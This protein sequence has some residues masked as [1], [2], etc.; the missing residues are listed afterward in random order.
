M[1]PSTAN[2]W[3]IPTGTQ[4]K[5]RLFLLRDE[6]FAED[7]VVI[8]AKTEQQVQWLKEHTSIKIQTETSSFWDSAIAFF[9]G[10]DSIHD[11]LLRLGLDPHEA[12][13][14]EA[15]ID[16]GQYFVYADKVQ[17]ANLGQVDDSVRHIK[18]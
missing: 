14:A 11:V 18:P 12:V 2:Y 7:E 5:E 10:E 16:E 17:G 1:I 9:K 8:L 4:L 13:E 15:A 3:V 6:N